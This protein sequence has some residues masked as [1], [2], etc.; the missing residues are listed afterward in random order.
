MA[1]LVILLVVIGLLVAAGPPVRAQSAPGG[2]GFG[3]VGPEAMVRQAEARVAELL[4]LL[5]KTRKAAEVGISRTPTVDQIQENL[6][7]A[8]A[9]LALS[10]R[11]VARQ[12]LVD[13]LNKPVDLKLQNAPVSQ[14]LADLAKLSQVTIRLEPGAGG[15]AR[16]NL[17]ARQTPAGAILEVLATTADL[18][19]VPIEGG[20][21]LRPWPSVEVN[22][23]K[24][25]FRD[26]QPPWSSEW[27]FPPSG[28][29]G[30]GFHRPGGGMGGFS[31]GGYGT[32]DL[33]KPEPVPPGK[34]GQP[35]PPGRGVPLP[36][37]AA[38][39]AR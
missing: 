4:D 1:R 2:G 29:E 27:G 12:R 30:S 20:V 31:G 37:N 9:E 11:Y 16:I 38:N 26:G 10:R 32:A 7:Q 39:G 21:A 5:E 35:L 34:P 17:D 25:I 14:A 22:G 36:A 3:N 19:V 28:R 15:D 23:R 24:R 33:A 18:A 6:V 8:R 13:A